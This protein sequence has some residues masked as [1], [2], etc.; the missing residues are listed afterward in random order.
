V[1]ESPI[2]MSRCCMAGNLL[3]P[4]AHVKT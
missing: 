2:A 4:S 1:M 3:D